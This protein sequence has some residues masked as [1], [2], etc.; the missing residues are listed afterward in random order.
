LDLHAL[1]VTVVTF[2]SPPVL[3]AP[4][5]IAVSE[6]GSQGK[7]SALPPTFLPDPVNDPFSSQTS[8]MAGLLSFLGTLLTAS[9]P[10]TS[11]MEACQTIVANCP[12]FTLT[13]PS[14]TATTEYFYA[15]NHY[16][17][18][19]NVDATPACVVFPTSAEDVS[20]VI[21]ILLQYPEVP[22][23]VKSGGHNPN[24]GF[25]SVDGGILI[26][27]QNLNDTTL[28]PDQ[29]TAVVGPGSQWKDVVGALEPHGLTVVG[30][31]LGMFRF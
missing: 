1:S 7:Q 25:S 29:N 26:S 2:A 21:K 28:S 15:T 27:F 30:G 4:L 17:S 16:W 8:I 24:A 5:V 19:T 11:S 18:N 22:F 14:G 31:R 10:L 20:T 12:S 9:P 3:M 6:F 13:W 23:A